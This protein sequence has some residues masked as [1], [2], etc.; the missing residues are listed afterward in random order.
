MKHAGFFNI[1]R[2][3]LMYDCHAHLASKDFDRDR[4]E[5]LERAKEVGIERIIVVGEDLPDNFRILKVCS[6][7]P[8]ILS[9]CVG[10]HPDHFTEGH[11]PPSD[12]EI[13]S[14]C[15][16]ARE[17][18]SEIVAIGEVGLDYWSVKSA[19]RR[20]IQLRS[21][22]RM[23]ELANELHL[24]LNVHSRSAGHYALDT[25]ASKGA[26]QVLMHAF[27][28]KAIYAKRAA[29]DHGWL[30]SIP[31]SL[32]RSSQ[33]QKLVRVLPLES[34]VLESDSPV[35]GPD[36]TQRNEPM[37][38][39]HSVRCIADIKGVSEE[40]VREVTSRKARELFGT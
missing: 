7:D 21:F 5:V 28:G 23:I 18:R 6:A 26:G 38:L 16:F 1:V 39:I 32:V 30:F 2:V 17:H 33:K 4:A 25:L 40:R 31:P 8:Q 29:E 11:H 19:E 13:E 34:L 20:S 12:E 37:N 36:R 3:C 35:L 24:P 14:I 15:T 10:L 9:P 22:E 27:D